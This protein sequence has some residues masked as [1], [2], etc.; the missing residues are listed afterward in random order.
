MFRKLTNFFFD[1]KIL[2]IKISGSSLLMKRLGLVPFQRLPVKCSINA[3]QTNIYNSYQPG[4]PYKG[5][6]DIFII[7]INNNIKEQKWN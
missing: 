4:Q 2:C 5:V 7:R 6:S 1:N 3:N